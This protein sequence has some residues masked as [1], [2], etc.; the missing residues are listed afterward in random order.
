MQHAATQAQHQVQGAPRLVDAVA[1][2]GAPVLQLLAHK[3]QPLLV[4]RD[5]LLVL[6][7]RLDL[8]HR[9]VSTDM[10][11][12]CLACQALDVDVK[13]ACARLLHL[14]HHHLALQPRHG[15]ALQPLDV[16]QQR[17]RA[18]AAQ[19]LLVVAHAVGSPRPRRALV[20]HQHLL[21]LRVVVQRV[22]ALAAHLAR[23]VPRQPLKGRVGCE[24]LHAGR[25]P[26][27][28]CHLHAGVALLQLLLQ[29]GW[30]V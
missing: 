6:D 3:D 22:A 10:Q 14:L 15:V 20:H 27:H 18:R 8:L 26:N 1:D 11:D 24:L 13:L 29:R 19:H 16:L 4:R 21:R 30:Q 7:H 17:D 28:G 12:D 2:Q 25:L 5:A 23:R 9:G